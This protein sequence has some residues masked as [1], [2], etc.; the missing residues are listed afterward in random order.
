MQASAYDIDIGLTLSAS[1]A[2]TNVL[3]HVGA[4]W[5]ERDYDFALGNV[6]AINTIGERII[7]DV[8]TG[9][10]R[11]Q[12]WADDPYDVS[13]TYNANPAIEGAEWRALWALRPDSNGA[14]PFN[15]SANWDTDNDGMPDTWEIVH[16]LNPNVA[17]NNAD[18]DT[19]GYTDLEEYLNELAAWPAPGTI[20]FTGDE[21]NRFARIFNW[22]VTGASVDITGLG[23]TTTFS[24]WQP[25]RYDT[26]LISN[27]TV[28]VDA[29]GQNAGILKLT[30]NAA[31]SITN[32]W[33]KIATR[34]EN[35][36]GCTTT[37]S[38]TGSLAT[39]ILLNTGT[40]RLT[41]NAG[42]NISGTFTNTGTLDVMTWNGTLPAGLVNLGTVLDRNLIV[43][44]SYGLSGANFTATIQGYVGHTYQLQYR[45]D[46][47]NG[48]WQNVGGPVNGA[49]IP[50]NFTHPSGA[51]A[52][53]RLYRIAVN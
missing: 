8:I 30:S 20:Y 41:G 45:D 23:N 26:A 7:Y 12:A 42:L 39:S 3:R 18:F 27:K 32:G 21:N 51:T 22:R 44:T 47:T 46:F 17:N 43:I 40:L 11:L 29:V 36:T 38:S 33:L 6:N 19:D 15:R 14:A 25:S 50:M 48:T 1:A 52:P 28:F 10:G 16:G 49:G 9:S 2:F 53:Q 13:G 34:F 35:S 5:W 37:V 31:L 4:R 24:F